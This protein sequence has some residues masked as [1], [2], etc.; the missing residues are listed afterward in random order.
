MRT[1]VIDYIS[2]IGL[3]GFFLTQ[4][5]PWD[6]D[7]NPLYLKNPKKI[8]VGVTEYSTDPLIQTLDSLTINNETTSVGIFFACDAKQLPSNYDALVSDLRAVRNI[9]IDGVQTRTVEITTEFEADLLVTQLEVRFTK[10]S[11]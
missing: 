2:S 8:Y 4:E 9:A 7:G 10:L 1:E 5:L 3:G 6:S 11:T